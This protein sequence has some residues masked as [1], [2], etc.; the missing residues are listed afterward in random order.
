MSKMNENSKQKKNPNVT[1]VTPQEFAL[2]P[3]NTFF[4][5]YVTHHR[6]CHI[7][8]P[9]YD[10]FT[11]DVIRY[12]MPIIGNVELKDLS[13]EKLKG[14]YKYI[15]EWFKVPMKLIAGMNRLL[16]VALDSVLHRG[17]LK[18]NPAADI[19]R[20]YVAK[21][22][23]ELPY[24]QFP[25]IARQMHPEELDDCCK[26]IPH[27]D[28][29]APFFPNIHYLGSDMI[30]GINLVRCFLIDEL[31]VKPQFD[32]DLSL[33]DHPLMPGERVFMMKLDT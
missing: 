5:D 27:Y 25:I 9:S 6:Q 18:D 20:E 1:N 23:R 7:T 15:Y 30:D 19:S 14:C 11:D 16:E 4:T 33:K 8:G 21:T 17:I 10:A 24:K 13:V 26:K 29:Y 3:L 32:A 2:M 28:V 31:E 22:H 12:L